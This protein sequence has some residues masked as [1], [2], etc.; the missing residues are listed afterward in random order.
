MNEAEIFIKI[1]TYTMQLFNVRNFLNVRKL[2]DF[3]VQ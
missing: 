3:D 2:L 1:Q